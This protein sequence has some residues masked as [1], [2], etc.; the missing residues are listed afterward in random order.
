MLGNYR[1]AARL[2]GSLAVTRSVEFSSLIEVLPIKKIE[3][4]DL[5]VPRR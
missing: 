5:G 1:V 2:V 4:N 3:I